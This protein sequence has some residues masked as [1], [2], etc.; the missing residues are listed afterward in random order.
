LASNLVGRV[1]EGMTDTRDADIERAVKLAEQALAT[2][3]R[4]P[5]AHYAKGQAL[6]AQGRYAAAIPEYETAIALKRNWV[7]AISALA[8][9]KLVAGPIED[10]IPLQEQALRL[11]PRDPYVSNMYNRIG[12]A[13]LLQSHLD[14]AIVWLEKA[15]DTKP[16]R[17]TPYAQLASAYALKGD[18]ERAALELVEARKLASDGRFSSISR[19]RA[20]GAHWGP[21]VL[22]LVQ[23]TYWGGLRKAG[24]PEE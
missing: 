5:V 10:A 16:M 1:L 6:R 9:C 13:H 15:R 19:L 12:V 4:N 8:D 2:S 17:S 22:P 21:N 24:M 7:V 20:L 11:S 14:E 18:P 23:A 3:P